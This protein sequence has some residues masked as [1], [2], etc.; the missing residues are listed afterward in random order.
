LKPDSVFDGLLWISVKQFYVD[1][2]MLF[3]MSKTR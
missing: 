2:G 3:K 1:A